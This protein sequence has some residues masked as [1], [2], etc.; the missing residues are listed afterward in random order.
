MSGRR[1][2]SMAVDLDS[3]FV[4]VVVLQQKKFKLAPRCSLE[5]LGNA[6][7]LDFAREP[8]ELFIPT[9]RPNETGACIH[10]FVHAGTSSG[11]QDGA[12]LAD[13]AGRWRP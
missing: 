7:P 4:T 8:S 1:F 12:T 2:L 10:E 6:L 9:A 3:D 11:A 13:S 5:V